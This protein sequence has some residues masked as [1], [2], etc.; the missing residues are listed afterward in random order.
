MHQ[1]QQKVRFV[2]SVDRPVVRG[3]CYPFYYV[4]K[5]DIESAN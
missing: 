3:V 4:I 5:P 1:R 2:I